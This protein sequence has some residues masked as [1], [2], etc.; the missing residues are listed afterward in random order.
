MRNK[1]L[2]V[3]L[4]GVLLFIALYGAIT[5]I[6]SRVSRMGLS[7]RYAPELSE[8]THVSVHDVHIE[9]PGG[10]RVTGEG[11]KTG[12]LTWGFLELPVSHRQNVGKLLMVLASVGGVVLGAYVWRERIFDYFL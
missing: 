10:V 1:A 8:A 3:T 9:L 11:Q 5:V 2:I 7:R 6:Y 12:T 4:V